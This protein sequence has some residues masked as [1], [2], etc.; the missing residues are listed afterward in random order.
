MEEN[1]Q[2]RPTSRRR[3][4]TK[5]EIFK[6]VY[7]P[8]IILGVAAVLI[9]VFIIGGIV[10]NAENTDN[11]DIPT[12][13]TV[14]AEE[15]LA[16]EKLLLD[17]ENL[18]F[19]YDYQG[20]I[21][22]LNS[23]QGNKSAFPALTAKINEYT[24]AMD[25]MVAW[26]S[27]ADIVNLSFHGLIADTKAFTNQRFGTSYNRN[28]ITIGEFKEI[29][30]YLYENDYVLV[31]LDD[32][33][34]CETNAEGQVV[35]HSKTLYLPHGKTPFL[36]TQTN[37]S[38]YTY[39]VDG[40]GDGLPDKNGAGFASRL[41]VDDEGNITCEMVNAAGET[42]TGD[43][44]LVPILESFIA[45][46]PEFSYKGA[47]A[48]LAPTGYDGIFGYRVNASVKVTKGEDYYNSQVAGA[49]K[50]V[51]A[52]REKGYTLACYTYNNVAYGKIS[53][54]EIQ[55]DLNQWENEI[56]PILGDTNILVFAQTSDIGTYS[57]AKFNVLQNAGYCRYLGFA[58]ERSSSEIGS[59]YIVHNRLL[60]TGSQLAYSPL[61]FN[62]LF[63]AA[64]VLDP[65]RGNIPE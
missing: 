21:D 65:I 56:A 49:T 5:L 6:E 62:G 37:L 52:L 63:D 26:S 17:A 20:A 51:N 10:K 31:D 48:I 54:G 3:K 13:E 32:I 27:P 42:V 2:Q 45:E 19:N 57:G 50:I 34:S 14:S 61:L 43:Y 24:L 47:R 55:A 40:N 39:M 25:R 7:L 12:M 36:L 53:A 22:L 41:V 29:L 35:C 11:Q 38:Y 4:K 46:H 30:R 23:F 9:L 44:D 16:V 33:T 58:A 59:N 60:V 1:T 64:S 8:T 15:A 28:F 18:V